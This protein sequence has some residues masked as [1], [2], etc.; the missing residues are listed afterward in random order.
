MSS[1][2]VAVFIEIVGNSTPKMKIL[3]LDSNLSDIRIELKKTNI[4]D[5]DICLFAKKLSVIKFAEIGHEDEENIILNDIIFDNSGNKFLYLLKNSSPDWNYF[6]DERKL[7]YGCTMS[8]D[9]IKRASIRAFEMKD[10]ELT[11]I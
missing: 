6:N 10:C 5:I 1:N 11:E 3:N 9:G 8:Y 7:D 2:K 4:S